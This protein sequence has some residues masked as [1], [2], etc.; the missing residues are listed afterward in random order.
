MRLSDLSHLPDRTT[1]ATFTKIKLMGNY[2]IKIET[3][4]YKQDG[5]MGSMI[6]IYA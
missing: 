6:G 3:E 2:L 5:C 1:R 4:M